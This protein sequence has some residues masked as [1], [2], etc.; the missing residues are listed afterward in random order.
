LNCSKLLYTATLLLGAIAPQTSAQ[1]SAESQK[2]LFTGKDAALAA[3]FAGLTVAMFP[4]DRYFARRLND[5]QSR[6][7]RFLNRAATDFELIATPGSF[8]IGGSLY[9]YGRVAKNQKITDL[10][11]HGTEAILIAS[12]T[13]TI[14]KGVLGRARPYFTADTNPRDFQ[15]GKGF[16]TRNRQSFPSGHSTTAF[17]AAA[18]VTS[19][20]N[21]SWPN[22]TWVVAPAMFGGATMVGLS[23]MYHDQHWASDVALGAAIGTFAGLK[24]VRYAHA[25]PGNALDRAVVG[26]RTNVSIPIGWS[27]ALP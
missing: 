17:A 2:P 15:L 25:H 3:G 14:L 6:A 24:I 12:A 5:P 19:E 7:N 26:K 1:T 11:W 8:F 21:H 13:T 16:S 4:V 23:R 27:F 22:A 18:A 20:V 10:G 9:V